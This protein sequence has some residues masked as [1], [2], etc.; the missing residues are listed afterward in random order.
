MSGHGEGPRWWRLPRPA[1]VRA[2]PGTRRVLLAWLALDLASIA[3]GVLNVVLGWNGIEVRLLGLTVDLTLYPPLVLSALAAIWVGPAW[4]IVPAYLANLASAVSSGLPLTTASVFA[5]AGAIETTILWGS[6]VLLEIDPDLRRRRDWRRFLPV[7]LIAPVAPSLAVLIWNS[8]H[9]FD[10]SA[11][12]RLWRGWMLGDFLQAVL[13]LAPLLHFAGPRVRAWVD[14]QFSVPPQREVGSTRQALLVYGALALLGAVVF[15]GVRMQQHALAIP[16]TLLADGVPL[17]TRLDELQFFLALLLLV[18]IV[19]TGVFATALARHAERQRA[20]ALRESLT[21][22]FDRRAFDELF[23]READRCRRLGHAM[24]LLFLDADHFKSV[25][26]RFGHTAGDRVL[27]Q[28]ALRIQSVV[29]DT[30]MLFRWG[31]E[32]FV[33]LLPHTP[34]SA[35]LVL[36]ERVRSAVCERR[37]SSSEGRSDVALTVSVGAAG[38]SSLQLDPAALVAAADSA[39]YAAKREGRDRVGLTPEGFTPRP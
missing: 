11:G 39:C 4:G 8:A 9:G 30:D 15:Q 18:V 13:V 26:D 3:T 22:C 14:R 12:Q 38:G 20:V 36:A 10:F 1:E 5:L 7:A 6:L 17:A 24:S 35:A 2:H 28:L 16:P 27:Q 34:P 19:A 33:L 32:E 21:G 23:R 29:R 25:N 31:G 37:F